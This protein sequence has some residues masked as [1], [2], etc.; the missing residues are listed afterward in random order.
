MANN[1]ASSRRNQQILAR[2]PDLAALFAEREE[3]R[4]QLETYNQ[5]QALGL[6]GHDLIR[7][8]DMTKRRELALKYLAEANDVATDLVKATAPQISPLI[9][10]IL[11]LTGTEG[12]AMS[13]VQKSKADGIGKILDTNYASFHALEKKIGDSALRSGPGRQALIELKTNYFD[14][15]TGEI[16][17]PLGYAQ[18]LGAFFKAAPNP[19]QQAAG[20]A[21]LSG[22]TGVSVPDLKLSAQD[23]AGSFFGELSG[24]DLTT[25]FNEIEQNAENLAGQRDS[26]KG[27]VVDQWEALNRTYGGLTTAGRQL[28]DDL[29]NSLFSLDGDGLQQAL[30]LKGIEDLPE[31]EAGKQLR[32]V[33]TDLI[34]PEEGVDYW[35][36]DSEHIEKILEEPAFGQVAAEMGYEGQG[37]DVLRRV[38]QQYDGEL[39]AQERANNVN[40]AYRIFEL[41]QPAGSPGNY[42]KAATTVLFNRK[43]YDALKA[44]R[45]GTSPR[46]ATQE[47]SSL[48]NEIKGDLAE[49]TGK[50]VEEV[51]ATLAETPDLAEMRNEAAAKALPESADP[52]PPPGTAEASPVWGGDVPSKG[53]VQAMQRMADSQGQPLPIGQTGFFVQP[54]QE[55]KLFQPAEGRE[56]ELVEYV[57]PV[58]EVTPEGAAVGVPEETVPEGEV[59]TGTDGWAD[60]ELSPDGTIRFTQKSNGRVVT[61]SKNQPGAYYSILEDVFGDTI[62]SRMKPVVAA[63][64]ARLGKSKRTPGEQAELDAEAGRTKQIADEANVA[65]DKSV[66]ARDKAIAKAERMQKIA[67][68]KEAKL[69]GAD[70]AV[71]EGEEEESALDLSQIPGVEEEGRNPDGTV[72]ESLNDAGW[73]IRPTEGRAGANARLDEIEAASDAQLGEWGDWNF[74]GRNSGSIP[75]GGHKDPRMVAAARRE[76]EKRGLGQHSANHPE[77]RSQPFSGAA[78]FPGEGDVEAPSNSMT[79][80][81]KGSMTDAGDEEATPEGHLGDKSWAAL[82]P[83][84]LKQPE[85]SREATDRAVFR[86]LPILAG[87]MDEVGTPDAID[88]V[89]GGR[90]PT[91]QEMVALVRAYS[92]AGATITPKVMQDIQDE[93]DTLANR[94]GQHSANLP[95]LEEEKYREDQAADSPGDVEAPS[96]L[97]KL[98]NSALSESFPEEEEEMGESAQ[99]SDMTKRIREGGGVNQQLEK[100]QAARNAP[101]EPPPEQETSEPS[102]EETSEPPKEEDLPQ[103]KPEEEAPPRQSLQPPDAPK[104]A[105]PQLP[106]QSTRAGPTSFESTNL[107]AVSKSAKVAANTGLSQAASGSSGKKSGGKRALKNIQAVLESARERTPPPGG[108]APAGP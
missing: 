103:S 30:G 40:D 4:A 89:L 94:V 44:E 106:G 62:P 31:S 52:Q 46:E 60:Y 34:K 101:P 37:L 39:G 17:N 5:A 47:T 95:E 97:T 98:I 51:Q 66:S 35:M 70:P 25:A 19:D 91:K 14:P 36:Q 75:S 21:W 82:Q 77:W 8:P 102:R 54:G 76:I 49:E 93:I 65:R 85:Y 79:E 63:A 105:P 107:P 48:V 33:V 81:E 80:E 90:L 12:T 59:K 84:N 18:A 11:K 61:V 87:M 3:D 2:N 74:S 64:K 42:L 58:A 53:T 27:E 10:H 41:G 108:S 68:A 22:Q 43:E 26:L 69:E 45:D 78:N 29:A 9:E 55:G 88:A 57:P 38:T 16:V 96:K 7:E 20:M 6:E 56:G 1:E 50:P 72:I 100:Q 24:L 13:T 28:R 67:D 71:V 99:E 23:G 83:G 92:P 32:Q 104:E 86:S 73:E 15:I